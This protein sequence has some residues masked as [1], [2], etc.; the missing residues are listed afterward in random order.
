[1]HAF[2]ARTWSESR[3]TLET[4]IGPAWSWY[5]TASCSRPHTPP[6]PTELADS[7]VQAQREAGVG[8]PSLHQV[9]QLMDHPQSA[10]AVGRRGMWAVPSGEGVQEPPAVPDLGDDDPALHGPDPQGTPAAAVRHG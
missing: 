9:T 2:Y 7:H 1:M 10:A 3:T 8:C 6:R 5:G 4:S